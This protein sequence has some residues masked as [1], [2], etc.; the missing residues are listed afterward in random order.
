MT[1]GEG[2]RKAGRS[3]GQEQGRYER[4]REKVG[5]G[6]K[7]GLAYALIILQQG[8]EEVPGLGL[9]LTHRR[10]RGST[11]GAEEINDHHKMAPQVG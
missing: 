5:C 9:G 8:E 7:E 6:G 2:G 3:E 10:G 11:A 4:S 1:L